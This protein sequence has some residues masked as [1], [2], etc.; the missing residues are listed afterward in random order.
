LRDFGAAN[1]L[2]DCDYLARK[3][4]DHDAIDL[5]GW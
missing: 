2:G 4:L 3:L 1:S 5:A